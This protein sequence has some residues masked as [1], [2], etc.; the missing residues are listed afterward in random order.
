[1]WKGGDFHPRLDND[2]A[3]QVFCAVQRLIQILL[4]SSGPLDDIDLLDLTDGHTDT[5][6]P[7]ENETTGGLFVR[8]I[9]SFVSIW[10]PWGVR[11]LDLEDYGSGVSHD[12]IMKHVDA[13]WVDWPHRNPAQPGRLY[14]IWAVDGE[15]LPVEPCLALSNDPM[16]PEAVVTVWR[17]LYHAVH[18][19]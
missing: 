7:N 19:A 12:F 18:L 5:L 16:G 1:M 8:I 2:S 11:Y 14:A 3:R 13:D 17:L 15:P 10:H 9:G 4:Q 6:V